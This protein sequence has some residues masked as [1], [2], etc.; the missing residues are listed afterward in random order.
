VVL[1]SVRG[2]AL[3]GRTLATV[4]DEVCHG[5]RPAC[6]AARRSVRGRVYC[7]AGERPWAGCAARAPGHREVEAILMPLTRS[8]MSQDRA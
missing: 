6:R 4:S 8:D 1:G 3:G 7:D 2:P 5:P